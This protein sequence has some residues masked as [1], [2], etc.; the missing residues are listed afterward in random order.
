MSDISDKVAEIS[1]SEFRDTEL[2]IDILAF[3]VRVDPGMCLTVQTEWFSDYVNQ[4]IF[5]VIRE[6]RAT[7]TQSSLYQGLKKKVKI[8]K[9]EADLYRDSV[10]LLF[11]S[12]LDGLN[13]KSVRVML[14]QLLDLYETRRI[15]EAM[16]DTL[17]VTSGF[18]LS[19]VK[20]KLRE[21]GVPAVLEDERSEGDYLDDF[22]DRVL[23]I[24]SRREKDDEETGVGI[25]TG[26]RTFDRRTGGIMPGEFGVIAGEPSVGKTAALVDFG[27][28][29]WQLGYNVLLVTGEMQKRSIQYRLDA[30]FT[31]IDGMKFRT[32]DL[33]DE[34][35]RS[36]QNKVE[37]LSAERD[38]TLYTA[39]FFHH[40]TTEDVE[41][42]ILKIEDRRGVKI[43][44]VGLDYLNIM[45]AVGSHGGSSRDWES[46]ADVVWDVKK[47][48]QEYSLVGWTCNQVRDAAFGKDSY[49]LGD[50]KYARAISE[51]AP[52]VV[53]LIQ[54]ERDMIMNRLRFQTLKMREAD[55]PRTDIALSPCMRHM[56]IHQEVVKA[57][58]LS[59][60]L[61]EVIDEPPEQNTHKKKRK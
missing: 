1:E 45:Q 2:E 12:P 28:H 39:S 46:Q 3:L 47:L 21:L 14:Q 61:S 40:F 42:L 52:I 33:D 37:L 25:P 31:R 9:S 4:T 18:D 15:L 43:Q 48:C 23:D 11:D 41:R 53:S 51:T 54:R 56:K 22:N 50:L 49:D 38:N 60:L 26:I 10:E 44:F 36:W 5:E 59:N 55:K 24:Q 35:I 17:M 27:S 6:T 7:M 34:D 16:A 13:Q 30:N 20:S 57:K 8:K 19:A 29:A 58:D 32:G